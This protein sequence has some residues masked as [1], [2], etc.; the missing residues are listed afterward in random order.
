[1]Y[2]FLGLL[3]VNVAFVLC[4]IVVDINNMIRGRGSIFSRIVRTPSRK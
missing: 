2:L 3:L 1:M 4:W